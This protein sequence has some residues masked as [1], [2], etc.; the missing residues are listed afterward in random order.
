MQIS[1]IPISSQSGSLYRRS[2]KLSLSKLPIYRVSSS[3][4][5]PLP[6]GDCNGKCASGGHSISVRAH[7]FEGHHEDTGDFL[8]AP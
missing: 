6:K 5:S 8:I 3:S 1:A 2:N 7:W 4:R